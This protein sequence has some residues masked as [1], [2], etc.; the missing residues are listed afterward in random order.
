[1]KK[2]LFV[3]SLFY[4]LLLSFNL[5]PAENDGHHMLLGIKIPGHVTVR[6]DS[7]NVPIDGLGYGGG[8]GFHMEVIPF[9]FISFESGFYVRRFSLGGDV[10]YNELQVPGIGKFR[11]PFS[12]TFTLTIGGGITYCIPFSGQII[13]TVAGADPIDL[14]E[15]DLTRDLGFQAKMGFQMKAADEVYFTIEIGV[16]HVTKVIKILQTDLVVSIGLDYGLF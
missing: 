12:D 16:E 13:Q 4:I 8:I 7:P 3:I 9:P 2:Y 5:F 1:M 11:Y 6:K 15:Q 10:I 14:P